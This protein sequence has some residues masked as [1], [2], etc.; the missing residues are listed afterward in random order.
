MYFGTS[1]LP[2]V[3]TG[4]FSFSCLGWAFQGHHDTLVLL[5]SIY[6]YTETTVR[7]GGRTNGVLHWC[8]PGDRVYIVCLG[9]QPGFD[10]IGR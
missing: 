8:V 3:L 2:S 1:I 10:I 7:Q 5:S 4:A 6:G 9:P